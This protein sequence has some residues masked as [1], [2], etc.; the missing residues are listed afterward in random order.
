MVD[1]ATAQGFS[2]G[3]MAAFMIAII[4][5]VV[6]LTVGCSLFFF[7]CHGLWLTWQPH[8]RKRNASRLVTPINL[9][10]LE[11]KD[12]NDGLFTLTLAHPNGRSLPT[13][14][15]G[16]YITLLIPR[17]LPCNAALS[18]SLAVVEPDVNL[19]LLK[20]CYSLASWQPN[21]AFYELAIRQ[22]S[23]GQVSTWLHRN[24]QS[25]SRI[26]VLPPRGEFTLHGSSGDVVLIAGGIGI[27]PIRAML[28]ALLSG[29]GSSQARIV[30]FYAAR[31]FD[32][33]LY[34][35][36]FIAAAAQHANFRYL[37]ILSKPGPDWQG[38]CGRLDAQTVL[39]RLNDFSQTDF[40]LCAGS[41]MMDAISAGLQE[42][43]IMTER[44]H[45]ERFNPGEFNADDTAYRI[46]LEGHEAFEFKGAPTLLHG[47]EQAKI[48][49][50][51]DCRAGH[52]GVCRVK[53]LD[54][55]VRWLLPKETALAEDEILSCCVTPQ[56]DLRLARP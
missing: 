40:Y 10:V 12:F 15:P 11:R 49:V 1:G 23:G 50:E 2:F 27:T 6:G 20:R 25:G 39:H 47:L 16:Q 18:P 37:P 43:G 29:N 4:M 9:S 14:R 53:M 36:E 42:S 30:L 21:P 13:Y 28:H 41:S 45:F 17:M 5:G 31:Y 7:L 26:R 35:E 22:V 56:S 33:L 32:D 19:P 3:R 44:I 52:C 8:R 51:S 46:T 24:M 55:N 48:A 54:G 34:H 38:L